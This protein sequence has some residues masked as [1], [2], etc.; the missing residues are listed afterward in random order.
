M[1]QNPGFPRN[2][3]T[4]LNPFFVSTR[5]PLFIASLLCPGVQAHGEVMPQRYDY[6][7]QFYSEDSGRIQV[8]AH[9]IR[10]QIELDEATSFRFQAL[11]DAIS[12]ASPTGALPGSAQPFL[13]DLEDTRRGILGAISRQFG[14]HRV[15]L[16]WSRSE[17]DDYVSRGLALSDV[18]ELNQKN[19]ILAFG[20]NYLDDSVAVPGRTDQRKETVDFF[21]GV[22]QILD[23]NTVL[24]ANLTV[25]NANG[26][27]NDPYKIV[28]RN[29]IVMV[30]D[31]S[32]G[33]I[34]IPVVN[35]YPENRPD[36]RNRQVLQFEGRRYF[37]PLDGALDGVLRFTHDDYGISS[38]TLQLEWRQ[39]VGER[40]EITPFFRYYHQN[41]ADFFTNS[42]NDVPITT[43]YANPSGSG[44]HYSADY[45]LSSL[46][47]MSLGLRL[48]YQFTDSFSVSAAYE[49]YAMK[50]S[51]SGSDVS[52]SESYPDA[53]LWTFGISAQF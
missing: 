40:F 32:G 36:S 47:T 44:P 4:P 15:E 13:A 22:T 31:G 8:E 51:G 9:Y 43:P 25:G 10:G 26:Y 53:N 45:R 16:E 20:L 23:K 37:E 21:A 24:T 49:R 46:D 18:L 11:S 41:A 35:I 3:N 5:K 7:Y 17:E 50:G 27:L 12:G 29:E 34:K 30:P 14:D 6:G 2:F 1:V 52:P 19:T 42:L 48:R 39:A 33:F 28:Q 38:Q